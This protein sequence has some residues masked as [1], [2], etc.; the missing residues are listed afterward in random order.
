MDFR[1]LWDQGKT[2]EQFLATA[3]PEHRP[4]WEGVYRTARVPDWALVP[5]P[6]ERRL[7]ALVEDWCIDTSSTIPLLARWTEAVPGLSLRLL[8]RDAHPEVMNRYLTDGARSIPIIIVL[9]RE[10]NELAHWGPYAAPLGEWVRAHKPP[11]LEKPEYIKGKRAWYAKDHGETTLRE[12]MARVG[13]EVE[14][15]VGT[16]GRL[17]G[18]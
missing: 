2:L 17:A 14:G 16:V 18:R 1:A 8:S 11:V 15:A 7:L 12:V 3:G 5:T 9:D 6:E 10:F 13:L 4:L